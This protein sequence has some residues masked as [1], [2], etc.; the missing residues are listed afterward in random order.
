MNPIPENLVIDNNAKIIPQKEGSVIDIIKYYTELAKKEKDREGFQFRMDIASGYLFFSGFEKSYEIF[1]E[2]YDSGILKPVND[3]NWGTKAPIRIVMGPET[4]LRT[5]EV[6]LG[7]RNS[8]K[9]QLSLYDDK[10]IILLEKL[11]RE[12]LIDIRV[13]V[14][15]RFHVKMY[16]FYNY[17]PIPSDIWSGSAN[18]TGEGLLNNIELCIPLRGTSDTRSLYGEWF[19]VLWNKST[20]NLNVLEVINEVKSSEYFYMEP[21][22]FFAKL[23]KV[24]QKERL[25]YEEEI[26][27]GKLLEFQE[28][29]YAIAMSRLEKYGGFILSNSP[30][31]GKSFVAAKVMKTY[32]LQYP[33]K[34]ILLVYPPRIETEWKDTI[35]DF[36]IESNVDFFRMS[37]LKNIDLSKFENKYSLIVVDEAHHFRNKGIKRR[38]SLVEI[39]NRNYGTDTLLVT[40][41][42]INLSPLD[43]INL[44][45][46]FYRGRSFDK[47]AHAGIKSIYDELKRD[48]L[49]VEE[50]T[51]EIANKFRQLERSLAIKIT[52]R[53]INEYYKRDL[54]RISGREYSYQ[55]PDVSEICFNYPKKYKVQIFDEI[56]DF[57]KNLNFEPAKLWDEGGYKENKNLLIWYKIQ[58]YKRLE[59]SLF[60]FYKS[61]RNLFNRFKLY[62]KILI[63]KKIPE[64]NDI[65]YLVDDPDLDDMNIEQERFENMINTFGS[66]NFQERNGIIKRIDEDIELIDNMKNNLEKLFKIEYPIEDDEKIK[67]LKILLKDNLKNKK[68]TIVFSQWADTVDYIKK[69]LE[70]DNEIKNRFDFIHG[71][72]KKSK[73]KLIN[74]YEKGEVDIIVTTDVLSEGVNLPRTDYVIN[75]DLPYNPVILVQRAGRALRITN[76]KKIYI[77]NFKPED[78]IDKEIEL[79]KKLMDRVDNMINIIGIDFLFWLIDEKKV[80]KLKEEELQKYLNYYNDYKNNLSKSNPDNLIKSQ[81]EEEDKL[82]KILRDAASKFNINLDDLENFSINIAKPFYTALNDKDG[83]VLIIDDNGNKRFVGEIKDSLDYSDKRIEDKDKEKIKELIRLESKRTKIEFTSRN[84]LSREDQNIISNLS[85]VSSRFSEKN[86]IKISNIIRKIRNRGTDSK[87]KCNILKFLSDSNK[88]PIFISEIDNIIDKKLWIEIDKVLESSDGFNKTKLD[89][90][91]K[92]SG[93]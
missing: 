87:L 10:V 53:I 8:A 43:L 7:I 18:F 27:R 73:D 64:K 92:Y 74:S 20:S 28:M 69:C 17:G 71:K 13:F 29:S 44:I 61:M 46:L 21:K 32:L 26:S 9:E 80:K 16:N 24:L 76:P 31:L 84:S 19:S 82:D 50:F 45:D 78:S 5:K 36:E 63:E 38:E 12:Q 83:L 86:K 52:W 90:I 91:I 30:G 34:K 81:V 51:E 75:F 67:T 93:D 48:I 2:L 55:D 57:L 3:K 49:N 56:V 14:E 58:L 35:K 89:A 22:Y 88:I 15:K 25:L 79:Y 54:E 6:L 42:P 1:K 85:R 47:F 37:M 33:D 41:T 70:N 77:R 66:L 62:K 60:A 68:P 59:S 40:A 11:I 39:I 65:Q 23:I 4:T 72:I